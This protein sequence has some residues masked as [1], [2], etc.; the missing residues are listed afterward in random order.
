MTRTNPGGGSSR[1][2]PSGETERGRRPDPLDWERFNLLPEAEAERGAENNDEVDREVRAGAPTSPSSPKEVRWSVPM[3]GRRPRACQGFVFG[4]ALSSLTPGQRRRHGSRL[5]IRW[6]NRGGGAFLGWG[7][8]RSMAVVDGLPIEALAAQYLAM[9]SPA[10]QHKAEHP[11]KKTI[12]KIK[13]KNVDCGG[14]W[15]TLS[16]S[17]G[18]GRLMSDERLGGEEG[19]DVREESVLYV[20][21]RALLVERCNALRNYTLC[22]VSTFRT[23]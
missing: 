15:C 9:R 20:H 21:A 13:I 18:R 1:R 11:P 22:K 23:A 12:N 6:N 8:G 10:W 17:G 2:S 3:V 19:I 14:F 7:M 16:Y 5:A 4:G